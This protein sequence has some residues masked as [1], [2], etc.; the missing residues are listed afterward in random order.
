MHVETLRHYLAR[1]I[2]LEVKGWPGLLNSRS[3]SH[4]CITYR[5]YDS[6]DLSPSV[7]YVLLLFFNF[8]VRGC[9]WLFFRG[10]QLKNVVVIRQSEF[11]VPPL[12]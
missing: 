6:H 7:V 8:R 12:F 2:C 4:G 5:Y 10:W 9:A 11:L 1:Q 3:R